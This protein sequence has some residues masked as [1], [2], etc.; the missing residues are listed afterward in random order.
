MGSSLVSITI[1]V[2]KML[3]ILEWRLGRLI[4]LHWVVLNFVGGAIRST[5]LR[6]LYPYPASALATL[7]YALNIRRI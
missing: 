7:S 4:P 2:T 6:Y 1:Q 5:V 3:L